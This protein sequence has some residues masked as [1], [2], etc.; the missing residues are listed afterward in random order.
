MSCATALQIAKH[1]NS[2]NQACVEA[3]INEQALADLFTEDTAKFSN[4]FFDL[5]DVI[6]KAI[7]DDKEFIVELL[8]ELVVSQMINTKK[9]SAMLEL[10]RKRVKHTA[11][12]MNKE[13]A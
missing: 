12:E 5:P 2:D 10:L 6:E 1:A 9:H 4:D 11:I 13:A 7:N 3:E 8:C